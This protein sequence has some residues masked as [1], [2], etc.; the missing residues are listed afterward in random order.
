[1]FV[2][3]YFGQDGLFYDSRQSLSVWMLQLFM[4]MSMTKGLYCC[5][6]RQLFNSLT[7]ILKH[8][9]CHLAH[10][11][12]GCMEGGG[13]RVYYVYLQGVPHKQLMSN[14]G[15]QQLWQTERNVCT[16]VRVSVGTPPLFKA[17][18]NLLNITEL[19]LN[20][21]E[22]RLCPLHDIIWRDRGSHKI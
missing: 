18:Q 7:A 20:I 22:Y 14:D 6:P 5:E 9:K 4:A 21:S 1:M 10:D 3:C 13:V 16:V 2:T 15:V 8:I 12:I 17:G 11:V 19:V